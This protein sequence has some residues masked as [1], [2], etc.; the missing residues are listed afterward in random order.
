MNR[1]LIVFI[2]FCVL[3]LGLVGGV[4]YYF[5]QK[6]QTPAEDNRPLTVKKA[7]DET[8][9]SPVASLDN[10]SVWYFNKEN[11]LFKFAS[12]NSSLSEFPLPSFTSTQNLR[13]VLW[14]KVGNDFIE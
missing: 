12:N 9:I 10:N 4:L 14:P 8:V 1:R 11:R 2:I 6:Q 13:V 3:I 5:S 7:L